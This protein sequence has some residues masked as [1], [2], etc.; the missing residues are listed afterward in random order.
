MMEVEERKR[1]KTV[2]SIVN[3]KSIVTP[4]PLKMIKKEEEEEKKGG[5]MWRKK[6]RKNPRISC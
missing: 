1:A 4:K 3:K 6:K 5:K 2:P